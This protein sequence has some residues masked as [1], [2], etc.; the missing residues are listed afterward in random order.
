MTSSAMP[1]LRVYL[2]EPGVRRDLARL[3]RG[4]VPP[5][6]ADDVVQSV[7][8][9]ALAADFVPDERDDLP[10]WIAGIARHKVADV[11]RRAQREPAVEAP[12]LEAPAPPFEARQIAARVIDEAQDDPAAREAL[13]W[14]AREHAGESW[15]EIAREARL[16]GEVVRKRISRFRRALRARWL[17]ALVALLLGGASVRSFV[18]VAGAPDAIVSEELAD[19]GLAPGVAYR[20]V[21][22]EVDGDA[23]AEAR[24]LAEVE[25]R[26]TR[27]SLEGRSIVVR[28][29]SR[30]RRFVVVAA[31]RGSSEGDVVLR[32]EAG[33]EHRVAVS[34]GDELRVRVAEGAWR[35]TVVLA[36]E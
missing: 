13:A 7:L 1:D 36:R 17:G 34:R 14:I 12:D 26:F 4:R 10:R 28:A 18:G 25:G 35:G 8:C 11:F 20:V 30:T 15:E 22:V 31:P 33:R 32:D 23:S 24:T 5:R 29:L 6:D 27:V 21:R 3:V 2:A 9:A 19:L 16:S